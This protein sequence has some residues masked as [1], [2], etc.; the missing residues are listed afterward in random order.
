MGYDMYWRKIDPSEAQAVEAAREVWNQALKVRDALPEDEKGTFNRAKADAEFDGDWDAHG[1][2]DGRTDRY[3]AA[4]DAV[5]AA[6]RAQDEA[7]QSYFRL[8]IFGMSA[9]ADLMYE[10]GMIFDDGEHPAWPKAEDFGITDED[11]EA[12]EYPEFFTTPPALTD[13]QRTAAQKYLTELDRILAWHGKET[14]GIPAH[15]FGSNDGWIVLPAECQAALAIYVA[16]LEEIGQDAMRNLVEN[17]IGRPGR[18]A[19]WLAYLNGAITHDGF[20]V[21]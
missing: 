14:P 2:Y 11:V 15:K 1:A 3:I 10:L 6:S 21:H 16:K 12:V 17:K 8:N 5:M 9:W 19:Q 7:E 20:E 4:Q 13:A 18:W